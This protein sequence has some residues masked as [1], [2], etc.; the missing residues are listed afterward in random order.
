MFNFISPCHTVF[1]QD[2]TTFHSHQ[3]GT[4]APLTWHH[5]YCFTQAN[6]KL[7]Q[8]YH[9]VLKTKL[10]YPLKSYINVL[11]PLQLYSFP[12]YSINFKLHSQTNS[13]LPFSDF[14]F[15]SLYSYLSCS[16]FSG[17]TGPFPKTWSISSY[18]FFCTSSEV[19]KKQIAQ[20]HTKWK[21][22]LITMKI[23]NS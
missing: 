13:K 4:K 5:W 3:R 9:M 20:V 12:R 23:A 8:H 17:V 10:S 18:S 15:P 19:V 16:I 6:V 14:L 11:S 22:I 1:L 7:S 2:C 21:F